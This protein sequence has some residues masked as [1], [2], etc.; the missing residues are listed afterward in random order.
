VQWLKS[1]DY[2]RDRFPSVWLQGQFGTL[3]FVTHVPCGTDA[4]PYLALM[5]QRKAV[6]IEMCDAR[7]R[8][9]H[10]FDQNIL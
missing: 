9:E 4:A 10:S 2:A 6:M 3:R 8:F 5:I 1:R 7:R